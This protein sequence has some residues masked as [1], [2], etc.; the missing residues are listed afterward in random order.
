M[1]GSIGQFKWQAGYGALTVGERSLETVMDYAA[2]QKEHHKERTTIDVY[3]RM[4]EENKFYWQRRVRGLN[5]PQYMKPCTETESTLVDFH[6]QA[7]AQPAEQGW[8]H[9]LPTMIIVSGSAAG[10]CTVASQ[11]GRKVLVLEQH[12]RPGSGLIRS[13]WRAI[14]SA[15]V[16]ITSAPRRGGHFGSIYEDRRFGDL[17]FSNSLMAEPYF[18]GDKR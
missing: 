14:A 12:D 16:C 8:D 11:A 15:R 9:L 4:D 7:R 3:E 6:G 5:P 10:S 1:D 17:T 13:L 2:R 18:V